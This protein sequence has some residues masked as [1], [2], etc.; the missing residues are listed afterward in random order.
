MESRVSHKQ[1]NIK[2]SP[3]RQNQ[4]YQNREEREAVICHAVRR[5]LTGMTDRC[6]SE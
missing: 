5:E 1:E 6:G 2:N 3:V 4:Q